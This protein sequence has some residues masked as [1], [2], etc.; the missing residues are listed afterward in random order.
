MTEGFTVAD[1]LYVVVTVVAFALL[2]LV[3]RAVQKL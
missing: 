3:V 1:V 2:A